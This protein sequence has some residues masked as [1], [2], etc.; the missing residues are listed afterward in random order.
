MLHLTNTCTTV[1]LREYSRRKHTTALEELQKHQR[2]EKSQLQPKSLSMFEL[3]FQWR[4][5]Y[6]K[7]VDSSPN[8]LLS[9]GGLICLANRAPKIQTERDVID[10]VG[11]YHKGIR[12]LPKI[13][14]GQER[15][16]LRIIKEDKTFVLRLNQAK[17]H[18][19]FNPGHVAI[20]CPFPKNAQQ[21][22]Q[23]NPEKRRDRN[24]KNLQKWLQRKNASR[25]A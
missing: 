17:C 24:L 6:A 11:V 19:C 23:K 9:T 16:I 22:L 8:E 4:E 14:E 5:R 12:Q 10:T 1:L 3:L 7:L 18:N 21:Y 15:T 20:Y 13:I 25:L 2:K